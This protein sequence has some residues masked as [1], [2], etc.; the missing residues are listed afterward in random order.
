MEEW[1]ESGVTWLTLPADVSSLPRFTEFV[2]RAAAE[3]G[4]PENVARY[5]YPK[6]QPGTADVGW[7]VTA[8]GRLAVEVRDRGRAYNPLEGA[9]PGLEEELADRPIGGLGIFL[10]KRLADGASY[11]RE[12]DRNVLSFRFEA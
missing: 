11:A 6:A 2:R 1:T 12:G 7:R 4:L 10:V 3:A 8:P 9:P 5:A